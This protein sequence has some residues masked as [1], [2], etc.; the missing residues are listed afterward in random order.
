MDLTIQIEETG[1]GFSA[2]VEEIDGV[3]SVGD[4]IDEVKKNIRE[5][6]EFYA[7]DEFDLKDEVF[8][9]KYIQS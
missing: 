9:Y 7:E 5:A 1:T 8:N 4:T 3:I 2:Y 6:V